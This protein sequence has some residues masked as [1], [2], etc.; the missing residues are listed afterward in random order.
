MGVNIEAYRARIGT[1]VIHFI[2]EHT[3]GVYE[4]VVMGKQIWCW[5][6]C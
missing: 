2:K 1:V 3:T 4:E 6:W 5:D